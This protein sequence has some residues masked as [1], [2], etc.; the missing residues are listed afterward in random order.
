VSKRDAALE[1]GALERRCGDWSLERRCGGWRLKLEFGLG[2]GRDDGPSGG[3]RVPPGAAA[4]AAPGGDP[5]LCPATPPHQPGTQFIS[6][7]SK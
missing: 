2:A 1:P 7:V 3:P 5:P 4:R 6:F